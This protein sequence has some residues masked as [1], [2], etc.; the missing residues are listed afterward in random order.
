MWLI[1][2]IVPLMHP[3]SDPSIFSALG[4][5]LSHGYLQCGFLPLRIAFPTLTAMLLGTS[6]HIPNSFL[7]SSFVDSLN[8]YEPSLFKLASRP[9]MLFQQIST[10]SLLQ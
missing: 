10:Q 8:S 6:I 5:V 1:G 4:K 3:G 9:K 7:V 2:K